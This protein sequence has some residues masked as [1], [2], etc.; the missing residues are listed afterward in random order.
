MFAALLIVYGGIEVVHWK[1][2]PLGESP[3]IEFPAVPIS[4]SEVEQ[5]LDG[6]F[7]LITDIEALPEPV[8]K[9]F[10]ETGGS[11]LPQKWAPFYIACNLFSTGILEHL[12]TSLVRQFQVELPRLMTYI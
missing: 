11:N 1:L 10:T 6:D 5:F 8:V 4:Q 3:L 9:A 2:R 12:N 7:Q